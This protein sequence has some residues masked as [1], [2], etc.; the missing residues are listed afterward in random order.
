MML[1]SR[2]LFSERQANLR[3]NIILS[4]RLTDGQNIQNQQMCACEE[5]SDR[6]LVDSKTRWVARNGP[7]SGWRKHEITFIMVLKPGF[8]IDCDSWEMECF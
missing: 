2:F 7:V 8:I 1:K 4:E 3:D 5:E 6:R